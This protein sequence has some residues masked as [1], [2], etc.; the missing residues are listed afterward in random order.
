MA[1]PADGGAAMSLVVRVVGSND[2]WTTIPGMP[3]RY[4]DTLRY[5]SSALPPGTCEYQRTSSLW[6]A[7]QGPAT[8]RT[9]VIT[10]G[11][12]SEPGSGSN[13]AVRPA[14]AQT[15]DRWGNVVSVS[16]PRYGGWNTTYTYNANNQLTSE[17]KP[18]GAESFVYYDALGHQVATREG[19]TTAALRG[20]K[21]SAAAVIR[22][23][24]AW[25]AVDSRCR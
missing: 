23:D 20:G 9:G 4:G 6:Y 14:I 11:G 7:W 5:P 19:R 13:T 18:D 25:L 1:A 21:V 15:T 8:T 10:I 12:S 24:A 22:I 17:H 3:V 16:D 2:A